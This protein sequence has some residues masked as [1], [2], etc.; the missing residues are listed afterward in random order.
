MVA[1]AAITVLATQ[2]ASAADLEQ[3]PR[4]A[5]AQLK[6]E[7]LVSLKV[8]RTVL[9]RG[10]TVA[11]GAFKSLGPALP[12]PPEDFA[13]L[14]EFCRVVGSIHP[15]G[16]S[17]IG[18]ELWLPVQ[19]WNGKFLQT[20]NGAAAG[21]IY[22]GTMV[23]PLTRGYAVANTDTG[24]KG[25]GGDF[26]WAV[27]HPERL[28]DYAYRAVH[29]L[30]LTARAIIAAGYGQAPARSYFVGCSTGGRQGLKE[31][32]RYPDDYDAIIAGAPANNWS[33]LIS[34][35]VLIERNLTGAD[36]LSVAKLPLL[37]E[38]AIAR[39]DAIDGVTDRVIS[40]P[41]KCTFDPATLQC[42]DDGSKQCLSAAE[43]AAARRIYRGVVSKTGTTLMPGT[44]PG[45]ELLWAAYASPQFHIGSSYLRNV[46]MHDPNWEPASFDADRD[47]PRAEKGDA[48]TIAAMDPQLGDFITQGGKL[49]IFHG[50][51]DGLIPYGSSVSYYRS[52][53]T[54]LG[55]KKTDQSVRFYLVPGMD[56]CGGG[57][58]A[59]Q[60]DWLSALENWA[61]KGQAPGA[62]HA[63][64]PPFVP[65]PPGV[66]P[67]PSKPFTRPACPYPQVARYKGTG[68]TAVAENFTCHAL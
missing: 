13:K 53:V 8:E 27:G 56:H 48:G 12:G 20:G 17:D 58:G 25:A 19:G 62:L 6:C 15:T 66:P 41:A 40:E 37:K 24:H 49:I 26:A 9:D 29:E 2:S 38:A 61:E 51:A 3:V 23:D 43:V 14:P 55:A 21:S 32:Q 50:T 46:V 7:A 28:I 63:L 31:A 67:P 59:F 64:H 10:E 60:I 35:S 54:K 11:A 5:P 22:Y 36:G 45:S 1:A 34:L 68:N 47:L 30:T 18:F 16:D 39:C 33:R 42:R 65:G 44:G 52:V 4:P 57:E